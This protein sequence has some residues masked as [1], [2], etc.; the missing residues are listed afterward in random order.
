MTGLPWFRMYARIIDDEK[1]QLLAFE[2]RWHFVALLAMKCAGILDRYCGEK[3]DRVVGTKL[4][5]GDRDRDEVRRRL[6]EAE[7]IDADWQPHAWD[8]L[9]YT[10]DLDR[11]S[12]ERKRR[13]RYKEKQ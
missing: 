1:L 5:L 12:A 10:S 3:L 2:D 7:L 6:S 11:T 8:R 13:Q 9:Q 4:G